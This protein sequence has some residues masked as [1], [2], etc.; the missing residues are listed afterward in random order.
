MEF[1]DLV[2]LSTFA[3]NTRTRRNV[4]IGLGALVFIAGL[5]GYNSSI[6]RLLRAL[7][8]Y[9]L[10]SDTFNCMHTENTMVTVEKVLN[11]PVGAELTGSSLCPAELRQPALQTGLKSKEESPCSPLKV[12]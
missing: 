3:V 8:R 1:A 6:S 10:D 4:A 11:A 2:S 9:L 7:R 5:E 12:A